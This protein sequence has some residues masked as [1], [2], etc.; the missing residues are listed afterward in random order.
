MP[1]SFYVHATL[2]SVLNSQKQTNKQTKKKEA[3]YSAFYSALY[4]IASTVMLTDDWFSPSGS[5]ML[6]NGEVTI[7]VWIV[8]SNRSIELQTST[9]YI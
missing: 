8:Q 4:Y 9:E 7:T 3:F 2:S 5:V 1:S 6:M